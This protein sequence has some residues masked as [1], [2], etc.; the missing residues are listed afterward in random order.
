[1]TNKEAINILSEM[2]IS[3]MSGRS[4]TEIADA[5]ELA[6]KALEKIDK[7][8]L[9]KFNIY[10]MNELLKEAENETN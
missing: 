9:I 4:F 6:I 3:T 5:L 10:A 2:P 1:M 7:I 8:D